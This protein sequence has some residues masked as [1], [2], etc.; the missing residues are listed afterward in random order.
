[1]SC[2]LED[3]KLRHAITGAANT[4]GQIGDSQVKGFLQLSLAQNNIDK[5]YD[6]SQRKL[7]VRRRNIVCKGRQVDH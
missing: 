1:M 3:I 2:Y 4:P 6:I 5:Q 7:T